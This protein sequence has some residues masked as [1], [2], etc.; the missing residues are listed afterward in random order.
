MDKAFSLAVKAVVVDAAGRCLLIRRSGA[1]RHCPGAWEWPGGKVDPGEEFS[2]AVV[3]EVRE[4]TS[5]EVVVTGLAGALQFE[6]PEV[7]VVMLCMEVRCIGGSVSLSEEHD[8]FDWVRWTDFHSMQ[9]PPQQRSFML[10]FA[11]SRCSKA[12]EFQ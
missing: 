10:S 12:G 1:N 6:M 4:E 3:R 8:C 9:L 11:N 7:F 5:L 2:S